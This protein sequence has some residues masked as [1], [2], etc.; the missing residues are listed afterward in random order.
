MVIE[1]GNFSVTDMASRE[2]TKGL[3]EKHD[4]CHGAI[5]L[6][7]SEAAELGTILCDLD[8]TLFTFL[9]TH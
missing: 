3:S 1:Y 2:L 8:Y 5:R 9:F 6:L 4:E 7:H